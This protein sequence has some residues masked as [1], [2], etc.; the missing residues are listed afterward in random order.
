MKN[1]IKEVGGGR[2]GNRRGVRKAYGYWRSIPLLVEHVKKPSL[3]TTLQLPKEILENPSLS[4]YW[5]QRYRLFSRYDEGIQLDLEGWFSATPE[6]IA[7][8]HAYR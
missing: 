8:H 6:K 1:T 7:I 5:L 2:F 4:R 3:F